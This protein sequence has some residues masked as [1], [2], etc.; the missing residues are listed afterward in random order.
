MSI[1]LMTPSEMRMHLAKQTQTKRLSLN[2]S[3]QTLSQRS[4]VSYS[5]IKKF[6]QTGKISLESLLKMALVLGS[7][8]EFYSLFAPKP[9]EQF[10]TLDELLKDS[11]RKRGRQ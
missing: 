5:V 10:N 11:T 7:L 6:E 4:G 8:K 9:A 3:Q 1:F 2:W